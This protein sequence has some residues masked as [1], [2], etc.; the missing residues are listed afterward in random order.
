MQSAARAD[1]RF[2]KAERRLDRAE[3]LTLKLIALMSQQT[4]HHVRL[5]KD[6]ERETREMKQAIKDAGET[7]DRL[8]KKIDAFL[9]ASTRSNGHGRKIKGNGKG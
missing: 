9:T 3:K 6:M 7:V 8:G 2:E 4:D 5:K 1:L